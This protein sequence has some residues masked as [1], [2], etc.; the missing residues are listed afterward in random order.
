[1]AT[2][3]H[4]TPREVWERQRAVTVYVPEGFEGEGFVH[5]TNDE[6]DLLDVGNRYYAADP[7]PFVVLT[8][9]TV[10]LT[11][12]I[13]YEDPDARYPH[14]YGPLETVAVV[15]VRELKRAENGTFVGIGASLAY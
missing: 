5:C 3:L 12:A 1:M 9:E 15:D 8:L 4:M 7:R 2:T 6:Q 11:A 14:V 10:R 13:R